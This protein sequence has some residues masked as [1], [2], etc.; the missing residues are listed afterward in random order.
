MF[1]LDVYAVHVCLMSSESLKKKKGRRINPPGT[2]V[3]D[4]VSHHWVLGPK[5]RS[6]VSTTHALDYHFSP[7]LYI[8]NIMIA[9]EFH[10][11]DEKTYQFKNLSDSYKIIY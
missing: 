1:C 7:I 3:R 8:L 9:Y 6:F 4:A 11:A 2:E 10:F 5:P